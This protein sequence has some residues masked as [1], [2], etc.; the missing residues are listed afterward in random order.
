MS[1]RYTPLQP[2]ERITLASL[3]QQ[4]R[5]QRFIAQLRGRSPSTIRR[6]RQRGRW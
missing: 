4:G 5:S 2:E 1:S 6:E 3:T